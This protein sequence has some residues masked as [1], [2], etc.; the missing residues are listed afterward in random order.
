MAIELVYGDILQAKAEALVNPVNCLGVMGNGLA[1][2]FKRAYPSMFGEY[3]DLC[4]QGWLHPGEVFLYLVPGSTSF[5]RYIA[6]T[7]TKGDW[8][9]PSQRVTIETCV[10]NLYNLIVKYKMKSIAIPALGCGEGR[11]AWPVVQDIIYEGLKCFDQV[12]ILVYPPHIGAARER[13][14]YGERAGVK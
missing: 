13:I 14:G 9:L 5:P 12:Q 4:D 7:A 11:M 8:R 1:A 2:Q 3:K 10:L 6:C